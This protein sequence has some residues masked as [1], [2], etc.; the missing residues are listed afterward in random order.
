MRGQGRSRLFGVKYLQGKAESGEAGGQG[1][2][3]GY[4]EEA[5][6]ADGRRKGK[7]GTK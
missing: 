4:R 6:R 2:G 5:R 7:L 1:G 3:E